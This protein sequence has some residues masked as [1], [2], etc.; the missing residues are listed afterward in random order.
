M[1]FLLV[2]DSDEFAVVNEVDFLLNLDK[3]HNSKIN[4]GRRDG[5]NPDVYGVKIF[6][7]H[8]EKPNFIREIHRTNVLQ[9]RKAK[10]SVNSLQLGGY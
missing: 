4:S 1:D 7:K 2:I 10:I 3:L 8:F 6:E 9:T 5:D